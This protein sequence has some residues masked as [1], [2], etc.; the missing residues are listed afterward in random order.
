MTSE[1]IEGGGV[2]VVGVDGSE[3]SRDALRW[4]IRYAHTTGAT[5]RAI[6]VWHF[7]VSY[8]WGPP[9]QSL[10]WTWRT[11]PA[12]GSRRRSSR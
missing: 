5:V 11:T 8:G 1:T 10:R 9:W 3:A 2:V 12:T 4:A 7:P 6:T